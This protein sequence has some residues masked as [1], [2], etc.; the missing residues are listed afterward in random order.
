MADIGVGFARTFGPAL[1][2]S[3]GRAQQQ[4]QFDVTQEAARAKEAQRIKEKEAQAKRQAVIDKRAA[5]KEERE[6]VKFKQQQ[7][8]LVQ[9]ELQDNVIAEMIDGV[10]ADVQLTPDGEIIPIERPLTDEERKIG[11]ARLDKEHLARYNDALDI[12]TPPVPKKIA[13]IG[14]TKNGLPAK[15][16]SYDDGTQRTIVTNLDKKETTKKKEMKINAKTEYIEDGDFISR[17][18]ETPEESLGALRGMVEDQELLAEIDAANAENR[19]GDLEITDDR[20]VPGTKEYEAL[21]PGQQVAISIAESIGITPA[22]SKYVK[23]LVKLKNNVEEKLNE[24]EL[25][26]YDKATREVERVAPNMWDSQQNADITINRLIE[27]YAKDPKKFSF[28]D[29][30]TGKVTDFDEIDFAGMML[31]YRLLFKRTPE[32]WQKIFLIED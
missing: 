14:G 20:P 17:Y 26:Y 24:V 4:R 30:K 22:A 18:I 11:V 3:A 1:E 23:E 9:S 2:R 7:E 25:K 16:I 32:Q 13:E 8:E 27:E 19:L 21:T 28:K 10:R 5:A 29:E 31:K 15:V 12:L 6:V